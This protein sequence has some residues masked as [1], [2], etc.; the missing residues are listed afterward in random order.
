MKRKLLAAVIGM[1]MVAMPLMVNRV[2][3]EA[4]PLA[5]ILSKLQLTQQQQAQLT[6]LRSQTRQQVESILNPA[7]RDQL[8]TIT[9]QGQQLKGAIAAMNL[10]VEQKPNYAK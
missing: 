1:A 2:Q 10:S 4:M 8:K 3:A 7:Q 9:A 6:Q 5:P